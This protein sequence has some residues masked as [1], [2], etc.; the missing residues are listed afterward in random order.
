MFNRSA[1]RARLG[2]GA[3]RRHGN[4]RRT[5]IA[6]ALLY[7]S[8]HPRRKGPRRAGEH[9]LG[10]VDWHHPWWLAVAALIVA[11]CAADA[12]LTLVLIGRGA[13]EVNPLLAPLIGG[14]AIAF[15]LVKIGLTGAGVVLLTALSRVRAFGVP[16]AL[17][18]YAIVIGYAVLVAYEL[19][20]LVRS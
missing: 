2:S 5:R 6:R 1:R 8:I 10:A 4:D 15:V 17:V 14:S 11:L 13:Y 12:I 9:R 3:E 19:N 7:G 20:L 16:V 18:L